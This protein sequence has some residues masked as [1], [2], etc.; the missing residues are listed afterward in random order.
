VDTSSVQHTLE[1]SILEP[2]QCVY[3]QITRKPS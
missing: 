3:R 1:F 2:Y